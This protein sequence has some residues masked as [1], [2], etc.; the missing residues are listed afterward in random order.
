MRS[1]E[2]G[3]LSYLARMLK[4]ERLDPHADLRA[5]IR[6]IE[7]RLEDDTHTDADL[8]EIARLRA[9]LAK[10]EGQS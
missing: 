3:T 9:A 7:L 4:R 8:I 2:P 10:A 6:L 5:A 1:P